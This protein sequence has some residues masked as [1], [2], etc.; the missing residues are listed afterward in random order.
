MTRF[1]SPIDRLAEQLPRPKG[2]GAEFMADL[3]KRP[4]FKPQEA[5][6]RGL[7]A[8]SQLPKVMR[9]EFLAA[10]KAKRPP[11]LES[12]ENGDETKYSD[13]QLPGGKNYTETLVTLPEHKGE[14]YTSK[15]W[16]E[17]NVL[18]HLRMS[19]RLIP[20]LE[21]PH[22]VKVMEGNKF[23]N[24]KHKNREEAE[25][26]AN[27]KHQGGYKTEITPL[28]SKKLL[29]IEEIQSDWHQAGREHGYKGKDSKNE[30]GKLENTYLNLKNQLDA[31]KDAGD[32][33]KIM[34]LM[35]KVMAADDAVRKADYLNNH[36]V[37][38]APFK[39][40][41]HEL[42]LKHAILDAARRG[43]HGIVITPGQ[44]Q[45]D[46]YKL[47]KQIGTV[48]Y[49]PEEQHFQAFAP[50]RETIIN[51]KGATPE[52]VSELIGKDVA[53]RLMSAPQTM[54]HHTLEG[55]DLNVGGEGMKVFYDKMIPNFLDKFGK[56]YGVKT[57]LGGHKLVTKEGSGQPTYNFRG[58]QSG[59]IDYPEES[60]Q[61]HYF[62][63]TEEMRADIKANG[64]PM[65]AKGGEVEAQEP[66]K[67]VKAYKLFR[68]HEKHPGKLFPLF[69]DSNTPVEMN[70]WIDAKEGEMTNGKVKSKIGP[71]AYRPGWHAG[72]LPVATHIGEKSDASLTAPDV[73]PA[74]HA[75]AEVEM[76][77]D[78]D[79]QTEANKRGV[80]K[81]GRL[82]ASRA[83]ITDQLPKG[84]HYRYKTNSNMT[85]NWLIGG[86]MKVNKML[87]DKEVKAINKAAG[88]ADLPREQP[89][90]AKKFG[91]AAGGIVGPEEWQAEEH[92]NHLPASKREANL[93]KFLK[94][95]KVK[96]RAY[97]GTGNLED[98]TAFDPAVTGKGTDQL[99][100]GFY[101]TNDPEEASGYSENFRP[102]SDKENNRSP[103]VIPAHVA[104][105]KP[106]KIGPKGMSLNDARVNL[107]HDQVK[108]IMGHAPN[109]LD[110]DES[111]LGNHVNTS[112]G[113]TPKM[114][115]DI[116]KLYTG[117]QLHAL[118]NDMFRD[119]PT[120][121][122]RALHK[123][124][125]YDG[126]VKDFGDGRKH[127]VAWFP[128]QIKSAIG[129]RGTYDTNEADINKAGGGKVLKDLEE[130]VRQQ[131]GEYGAKRVQR[132]A[133]EIPGLEGMFSPDALRQVFTGD[134]AKALMTM[135]PADFEKFAKR[136]EDTKSD[137]RRH[138]SEGDY[139]AF[140]DYLK[141]L[142]DLNSGFSSVPY[143]EVGK[144]KPEYLPT[145][146]GHE[147]R[148][149][150][151]ALTNKGV[152]KS[153]VQLLPR[154]MLREELPRRHPEE[155]IEALKRELGE[156]RLV[157]PQTEHENA[158]EYVRAGLPSRSGK[159]Y[160]SP[161]GKPALPDIYAEGG[162]VP[163]ARINFDALKAPALA[164]AALL[165]QYKQA[166]AGMYTHQMPTFAQWLATQ[167]KAE[168]GSIKPIGYTKE[169]VTVAPDLN[170]MKYEMMSVKHFTKKAK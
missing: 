66:K 137:S 16:D 127:Y 56:K 48:A 72:D 170:A 57:E 45:A 55:E 14:N 99:G 103:G 47:S 69:V 44:E 101:L 169:K 155:F 124:T 70:K 65:Y 67:T 30:L 68:V 160:T 95:S 156:K 152:K 62:P 12:D 51:E 115:H 13:Y 167:G 7:H 19:D 126:V 106:I 36:G 130:Q 131:K 64:L 94:P 83:H 116:A 42:A 145:I 129:N 92:V 109:I 15:H 111:P 159:M 28:N 82:I 3:S 144:R 39:K 59:N 120:T 29:H 140:D 88:A 162:P 104:I 53:K 164:Q 154:A 119:D 165:D 91:F 4:G 54:G 25:R 118:E 105:R 151:R 80:N 146:E 37:P 128:E 113:V 96:E 135:N 117:A 121:Y 147:G 31:A 2:T 102:P 90:K 61:L 50:N 81:Q 43:Y 141:H 20:D 23:T 89:F 33:D 75:W 35:P 74:N 157:V 110:P 40:D 11:K 6:D 142:A 87:T 63:I 93:A 138:T 149:R 153:L 32:G 148:H 78:V 168:G 5:E 18:A 133:D 114:I 9:E 125:G 17:P 86:S 8:L 73:R 21:G 1:Y 10:L 76:P 98:L 139:I 112:R 107:S 108:Q 161:E 24:V 22:N 123:V 163:P 49:H 132:A 34:D 27:V 79:W 136:M 52:R 41:W 60:K 150:S 143:L 100:S 134:N 26:F 38:D 58:E 46:R 122:R 77:N 158:M 85:G 71:L 97:H 166:T 84:G